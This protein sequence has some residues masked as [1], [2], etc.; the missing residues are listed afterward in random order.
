VFFQLGYGRIIRNRLSRHGIHLDEGQDIHRRLAREASTD[1]RFATLDLSNASD[2]VC[3]NLVKLL[4]PPSWFAVLDSL[5]SKK[6]YFRGKWYLLEKFSSMGNGFTFELETL[7]FLCLA[8]A[9]SE[10]L[11]LG[12]DVFAFGD[13]IIV[14]TG[15]SKDV[16]AAL[17]FFGLKVN[18]EKSFVSGP[19]RESCGG[20]YFL[21]V[22]VRPF[23]LKNSPSTPQQLISFANGITRSADNIARRT[24]VHRAW[25]S[26]LDGLPVEI[27]RLRGP[28]DLGDL[29]I[30]DD[31]ER[32]QVRRR[33]SIR[34][35]RVYRPA[36]FRKVSWKHFSPDV[37]LA[38]A[39]YGVPWGGGE[40]IPRDSVSGYKIGWVAFS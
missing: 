4:L 24:L 32:W 23:F 7:V 34:Y 8:S 15:I 27:R 11:R 13:D 12:V 19:F 36:R 5:R 14:P 39:V 26:I 21:G 2:T 18:D 31:R 17:S 22:D 28:K 33:H 30:H 37:L 9:F 25:L 38:A 35:V 3:R 1:G 20:D 10:D 16:I 6:T 29:V 40:I